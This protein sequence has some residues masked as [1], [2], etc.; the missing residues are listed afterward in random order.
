MGATNA[1]TGQGEWAVSDVSP[2]IA[3]VCVDVPVDGGTIQLEIL[4]DVCRVW[5]SAG[6]T[7][8]GEVFKFTDTAFGRDDLTAIPHF[9]RVYRHLI[10]S[11]TA[12]RT[13]PLGKFLAAAVDAFEAAAC[14]EVG[15]RVYFARAGDR[16]KIGW[17]RNVAGRMAQLQTANA[18]PVLLL[19]TVPGGRLLES[20]LHNEYAPARVAGEWFMCTPDLLAHIEAIARKAGN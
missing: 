5:D 8:C 12:N 15:S 3:T 9:D 20:R 14:R 6:Y 7:L 2:R 1:M 19:A 10:D 13:N 17:S 11:Y 4:T 18:D 16:I